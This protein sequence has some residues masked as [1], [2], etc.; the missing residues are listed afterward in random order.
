MPFDLAAAIADFVADPTQEAL[1]LPKALTAEQR[2]QAKRL[3]D[4]H[5]GLK[6][7]S[8]G[9]GAE[10]QLHLFKKDNE[11]AVRVKNTFIDDWVVSEQAAGEEPPHCRSMPTKLCA[12]RLAEREKDDRLALSPVV[13]GSPRESLVSAGDSSTMARSCAPCADFGFSSALPELPELPEGFRYTVRD[14]FIHID[15]D[16]DV[17]RRAVQSM[18][19]GAFQRQLEAESAVTQVL[20]GMPS[21][22]P[23]RQQH[24]EPVLETYRAG[25]EVVID[26][27]SKLPDF[28]G[29]SAVVQSYDSATGRYTVLMDTP[30][31]AAGARMAKVKFENLRPRLPPPPPYSAAAPTLLSQQ[32]LLATGPGG[33]QPRGAVPVDASE[34]WL[35]PKPIRLDGLV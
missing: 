6:C 19:H 13:E 17:D 18:P 24:E 33:L 20:P 34:A 5:G 26:G 32:A 12:G 15:T 4:Q 7:E 28:N 25:S 16:P 23:Q 21:L 29:R 30:V 11:P 9:F 27:L 31:G 10:R 2:K 1:E 14:T 3:A 8:F 22:S 35:I